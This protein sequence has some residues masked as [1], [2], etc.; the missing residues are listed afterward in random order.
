MTLTT[1]KTLHKITVILLTIRYKSYLHESLAPGSNIV[2]VARL[3]LHS[4]KQ[5]ARTHTV[6]IHD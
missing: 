2:T 1:Y 5:H 6:Q 4:L 3:S